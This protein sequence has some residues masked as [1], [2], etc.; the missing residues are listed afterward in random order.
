[1]DL[2]SIAVMLQL[3]RPARTSW[4]LLGDSVGMDESK[5]Q[6]RLM[7]DRVSYATTCGRYIA[8]T[9]TEQLCKRYFQDRVPKGLPPLTTRLLGPGVPFAWPFLKR[10]SRSPSAGRRLC[11]GSRGF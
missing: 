1:M 5:R 7:A 9:G 10:A 2:Q 8:R 11:V 6:A 4:G 3:V